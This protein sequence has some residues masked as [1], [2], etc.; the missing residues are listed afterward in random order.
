MMVEHMQFTISIIAIISCD[1]DYDD[2]A[3][4]DDGRTEFII[5]VIVTMVLPE[6]KGDLDWFCHC[7]CNVNSEF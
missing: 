6:G 7:I 4:A 5:T 1:T 3:A 2:D